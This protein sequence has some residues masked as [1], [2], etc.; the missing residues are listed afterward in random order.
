MRTA[1]A[2]CAVVALLL[3]AGC[4]AKK[5]EEPKPQADTTLTA[6]PPDTGAVVA[7]TVKKAETP[8]TPKEPAKTPEK[9]KEPAETPSTGKPPRTGR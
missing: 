3:A 6:P 9:P 1:I 2:A 7:D 5:A 4:P 8:E